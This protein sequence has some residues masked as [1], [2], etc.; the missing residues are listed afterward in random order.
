MSTV[1]FFARKTHA[2]H[3]AGRAGRKPERDDL[4]NK[5]PPRALHGGRKTRLSIP[6]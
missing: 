1:N 4:G 3:A 5:K 6:L 2:G